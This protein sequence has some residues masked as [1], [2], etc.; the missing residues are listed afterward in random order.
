VSSALFFY[1]ST[2]IDLHRQE[3][4]QRTGEFRLTNTFVTVNYQPRN[5]LSM[6]LGY[7]ASRRIEF[8]A[9]EKNIVDSLL[10]RDLRQGFRG[11]AHVRLP[12][13]IALSLRG[14]YR[15]PAGG[16]SSGYSA[17]GGVRIANIGG[18]GISTAGQYVHV[19]GPYTIGDDIAGEVEY[20][21]ISAVVFSL[22]WNE[23]AFVPSS[24]MAAAGKSSVST[25]TGSIVWNTTHGWYFTVFADRILDNSA[26]L[27]RCFAE[28]GFH[29]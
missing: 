25:V 19:Q 18:S 26:I 13:N 20:S 27:Y 3:G 2:E 5:W 29:F 1:Q 7:D 9:T 12:L 11:G 16:L 21:P 14:G 4:E 15:L 17:G 10:D 28:A 22:R 6:N 23:Y 24:A 8:L